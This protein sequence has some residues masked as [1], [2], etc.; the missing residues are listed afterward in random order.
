MLKDSYR[1]L[2]AMEGSHFRLCDVSHNPNEI[3]INTALQFIFVCI[4]IDSSVENNYFLK[5]KKPVQFAM[6]RFSN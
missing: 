6:I 4:F 3:C 5:K 2:K 1:C